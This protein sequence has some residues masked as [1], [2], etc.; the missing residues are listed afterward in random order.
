MCV[1]AGIVAIEV[2]AVVGRP[3]PLWLDCCVGVLVKLQ[4]QTTD[5]YPQSNTL[6]C[7][8]HPPD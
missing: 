2:M 8:S 5:N 4:V 7:W 1:S 6:Y 3:I